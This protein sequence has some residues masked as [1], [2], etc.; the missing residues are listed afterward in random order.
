[1]NIEAQ[2]KHDPISEHDLINKSI[3]VIQ[4]ELIFE[5]CGK[6]RKRQA[7]WIEKNSEHFRQIVELHP[8]LVWEYP[9]TKN[10]LEAL[11]YGE[12]IH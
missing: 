7:E 6:D 5:S 8:E 9:Q 10:D 3:L 4:R 12:T 11:L 1:M 2:S